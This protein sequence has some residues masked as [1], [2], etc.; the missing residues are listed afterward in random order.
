MVV[1]AGAGGDLGEVRLCSCANSLK[2][3]LDH[4]RPHFFVSTNVSVFMKTGA[5]LHLLG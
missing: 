4:S 3:A 5:P 2:C 1:Q